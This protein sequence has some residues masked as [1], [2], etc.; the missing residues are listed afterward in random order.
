MAENSPRELPQTVT[1]V[2]KDNQFANKVEYDW[3]ELGDG[4]H[5]YVSPYF[6]AQ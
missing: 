4:R 1:P 6:W 5:H 3:T 2:T